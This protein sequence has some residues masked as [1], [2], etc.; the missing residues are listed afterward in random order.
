MCKPGAEEFSPP[1]METDEATGKQRM[2]KPRRIHKRCVLEK[3]IPSA[4]VPYWGWCGATMDAPGKMR[5]YELSV[6]DGSDEGLIGKMLFSLY[7]KKGM[8]R[9]Y[10][11]EGS[12]IA[13]G[14]LKQAT[15][16]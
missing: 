9:S 5:Q 6:T 12:G 4:E 15:F 11:Y 3:I 1:Q 2:V 10:N 7:D 14:A 13:P 8:A 16:L